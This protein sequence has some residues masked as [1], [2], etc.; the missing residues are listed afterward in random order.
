[1]NVLF[2]LSSMEVLFKVQYNLIQSISVCAFVFI[3]FSAK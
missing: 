2:E 1:M 3:I